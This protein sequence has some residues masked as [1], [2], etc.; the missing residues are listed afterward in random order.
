MKRRIFLQSSALT[1]LWLWLVNGAKAANQERPNILWLT[2]EDHGPHLGCYG[3]LFADT[4]NLDQLAQR[5]MLFKRAWSTAPV[6]AAARTA[7]ISGMYPPS[8]GAEHMRS[9]VALPDFIKMYP[10]ILREAGYYCSNNAKEDYNLIEPVEPWDDSSESGHW[11]N[12]PAGRPFFSVFNYLMTHESQIRAV[13]AA[14]IHNPAEVRVPAYQP[15]TPEVRSNWAQYYDRL[16]QLDSAVGERLA[17]LN[18]DGLSADTIVFCFSDHGSGLPRSKRWP[19]NSGL[20]VPLIVY[21]PD[22]WR[23]LAPEEYISGGRSDRL[24]DFMDLAPTVISLAGS[25]PPPVMHGNAFAGEYQKPPA[26]YL[27]A[28]RGRMDERYDLS[29]TVSDG[30]FLYMRHFMPHRIYGQYVDYMFETQAT[31]VWKRMFDN[32]EL[33]EVQSRFW[34][35]KPPEELYDLDNDPDEINNLINSA[36][37]QD[38]AHQLREESRAW[39]MEK[40]DFGFLPENEIHS[41]SLGSTPYETAQVEAR[42]PLTRIVAV[43]EMASSLAEGVTNELVAALADTDSAVRYWAALGLLMRKNQGVNAGHAALLAA[44]RDE[45]LAVRIV[46]AEALGTFGD[47]ADTEAA[48][49]TLAELIRVDGNEVFVPMMALA[50]LDAMAEKALPLRSAIEAVNADGVTRIRPD[51][52]EIMR[53]RSK[54]L[55]DL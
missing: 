29:R 34:Q 45:A 27:H 47:A 53:L 42:Y 7:L 43:A 55:T 9:L 15:D 14:T 22:K 51:G 10:Q 39:I 17:E 41:R 33:N 18:D 19:Y 31:Q 5:G 50:A 37:H 26:E 35:E 3:D 40:R 23:H 25:E 8:L 6:C 30:R 54:I 4:P 2:S 52:Y 46:A 28:F 16:S 32:G 11:R 24:V 20:H 38:I 48:L 12:R 44:L 49:N 13:D 21:F 36:Q 1:S